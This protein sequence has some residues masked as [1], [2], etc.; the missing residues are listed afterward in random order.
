ME[1]PGKDALEILHS[2]LNLDKKVILLI[3]CIALYIILL[4]ILFVWI[5][6]MWWAKGTDTKKGDDD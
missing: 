4:R 2:L 1:F 5:D 3:S 6:R